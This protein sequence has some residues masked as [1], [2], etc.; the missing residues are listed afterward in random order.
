[1]VYTNYFNLG[2]ANYRLNRLEEANEAFDTFALYYPNWQIYHY[3]KALL[4]LAQGN[5]EEA[6]KEIEQE[7]NEFFSLYGRNFVYFAMGRLDEANVL[8]EEFKERY[9]A[10]DPSN[11]ADLYAFRGDYDSSFKELDRA[12]EIKD[13]VLIEALTYPSFKPMHSDP[14]WKAFISKIKLP[15]DHGYPLE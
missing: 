6:L 3:M 9:G 5:N 11:L 4:N 1:M 12:L 13:P 7:S 10:T 8:F 15:K 2:F 14:R